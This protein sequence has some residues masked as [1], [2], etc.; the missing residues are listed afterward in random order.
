[1]RGH[2]RPAEADQ[3]GLINPRASCSEF[4]RYG[5]ACGGVGYH[6]AYVV[7]I[8]YSYAETAYGASWKERG[9]E[10]GLD[11]NFVSADVAGAAAGYNSEEDE[12]EDVAETAVTVWI[13]A[14]GIVHCCPDGRGSKQDEKDRLN[15]KKG[16]FS[17]VEWSCSRPGGNNV[18]P[19]VRRCQFR[20]GYRPARY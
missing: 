7:D 17:S 2:K 19:V 20:A 3:C 12:Y 4:Y 18:C 16:A 11:S 8:E 15:V 13:L 5:S 10:K 6:I 14:K 1:M 9:F